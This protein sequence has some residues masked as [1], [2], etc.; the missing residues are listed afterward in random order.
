MGNILASYRINESSTGDAIWR[1]SESSHECSLFNQLEVINSLEVSHVVPS[2]SVE[3]SLERTHEIV[4]NQGLIFNPKS[5]V[6]TQ[7]SP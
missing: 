2:P 6:K 5:I 7:S 1:P 3:T 4:L